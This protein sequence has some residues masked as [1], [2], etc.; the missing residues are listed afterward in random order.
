MDLRLALIRT[1]CAA[2]LIS[3]TVGVGA[4]VTPALTPPPASTG[5]VLPE[6]GA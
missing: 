3:V 1:A 6:A 5:T 4:F 2:I